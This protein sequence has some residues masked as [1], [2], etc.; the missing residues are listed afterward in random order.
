MPQIPILQG[1][2]ADGS[3]DFRSRY[4][5]N[6]VPVP[7]QQGISKGYL[8]PADGI[9]AFATGPGVD[10]GGINWNGQHWRVMG[11]K[12]CRISPSG[13]ITIVGDVGAGG[14]VTM[15]YS[16]DYLGIAS[17]GKLWLCN[18]STVTAV[19][20]PDIGNVVDMR[21][22][23]G[24][25]L[26]TDGEFLVVTDL[27]NPF[28]VNPLKYGSS[29]ADPDPVLAVDELRN[30]AYALNRHTIEVFDNI[31]GT[32]FPFQRIEGAQVPRGIVG[33][34]AYCKYL[35]TFAFLGSGRNEAPAVYLMLPGDTQKLSTD[36]I[37]KLL[38]GYTE[39]QLATSVMEARIYDGREHLLLH[40]PDQ[41]LAFDATASKAFEEQVWFSMTSSVVGLG[42][43]RARNLVRVNDRWLAGDPTSSA[44]GELVEDVSSHYGQTIGW[45][46]DTL[47][48]Y[49]DGNDAIVHELE[50]VALPG[51]VAVGADPVVWTSYSTDGET[52]G[53]ERP[54]SAGR[55]GDRTKRIAWRRLG[56]LRNY[57]MQR[58]RGTSDA[59]L[60]FAR[61][62]AQI[63]PLFTRPG[64]G[65]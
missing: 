14:Q 50:L 38:A 6:M 47:I 26:T 17:A 56:R 22:I 27:T 9:K 23:A 52:W 2:Y 3:P 7:K 35:N 44:I 16:F 42:T 25:W 39:A 18:G 64:S 24:Y 59:H 40:L 29:E 65:N 46:F 41:C 43:Y 13:A 4:P 21:W 19:S 34:H 49:A 48:L 57:R 20:D 1:I 31:G 5:R 28:S 63:E 36:E 37:D 8:R 10:R 11:S 55:L 60:A 15:D 53:Q 32:G 58:F 62:Q 54:C 61:L 12:L 30:E 33:T 45:D 51:R